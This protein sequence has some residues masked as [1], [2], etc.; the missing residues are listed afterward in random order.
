[1]SKKQ[2]VWVVSELYY[3]ELTSTG[4][5]LTGI[6]EGLADDYEVS[7]LCGQPSYWARGVRAPFREMLNRVDVRRCR[8]TTLDKNKIAGKFFNLITISAAIFRASLL[9]FQRGDIVIAVTNPPMLP[10][11]VAL[12]CELKGARYVLR[13]EDVYPEVM[14]RIGMLNPD[15]LFARSLDRAS[16]WLYSKADRIIVLGR[17]MQRLVTKKIPLHKNLVSLISNWGDLDAIYP[18]PL[19]G[20]LLL[21]K[22]NLRNRFIVQY[23]GNIGRTHGIKDI[24]D[25]VELLSSESEFHFL[26]IGWGAKKQWAVQQKKERH[27]EHLTILD[28]L[29]LDQFCDGLNACCVAIISFSSNMAGISVPSR[30]YNVMA[31]GKPLLAVCDDDSELAAVVREENIGWV[32]PPGC[33]NLIVSAL[34]EAKA[35]PAILRA[36][37]ERAR[38][39]AEIKYKFGT[40]IH[41]YRKLLEGLVTE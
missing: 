10:Y 37:G 9:Y 5:F 2:R 40:V 20:N 15:S 31:A 41:A 32:I 25:A 12:A 14:T 3:P 7:V 1:M 6:A 17:D 35:N 30:M 38:K 28:P 27:L 29:P 22:L 33:P 34:R 21:D 19:V 24:T 26:L 39:A 8:A 36:M 13:I 23:C 11:L 4:Y 18:K 16:L